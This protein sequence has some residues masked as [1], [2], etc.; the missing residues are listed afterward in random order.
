M[1]FHNPTEIQE[2][3]CGEPIVEADPSQI[4]QVI[5]NLCTNAGYAMEDKGGILKVTVEK[6]ELDQ[7]FLNKHNELTPG[8]H[9]KITVS[10]TGHGIPPENLDRIFEPYFTT[11]ETGKGTGLGLALIHGIVKNHRGVIEVKSDIGKG[12]IFEVYLPSVNVHDTHILASKRMPTGGNEQIMIVDD[13][14]DI[15]DVYKVMLNDLGYTVKTFTSSLEALETYRKY[16]GE[17]DLVITDLSM[18]KLAGD[19]FAAELQKNTSTVP[20]IL[21]TGYTTK[22]LSQDKRSALGIKAVLDKPISNETLA[23]TV[24]SVLDE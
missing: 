1:K 2:K 14:Q 12:S 13:E 8:L 20:V 6:L 17:F 21:C 22:S 7:N 3:Y 16:S 11:K 9:V 19:S 18:P 5:M 24:R 4:H 10:D 23:H 15:V